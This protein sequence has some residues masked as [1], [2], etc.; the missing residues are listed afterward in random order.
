MTDD[1][2]HEFHA[3]RMAVLELQENM[4]KQLWTTALQVLIELEKAA[5]GAQ[6]GETV[7]TY[8]DYYT[9]RLE[10]E[11]CELKGFTDVWQ[12]RSSMRKGAQS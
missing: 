8:G 2:E 11:L 6:T 12:L 4:V 7:K 9:E 1:Q 5:K 10:K 3:K